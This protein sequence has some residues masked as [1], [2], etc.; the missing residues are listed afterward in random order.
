MYCFLWLPV[1]AGFPLLKGAP[2]QERSQPTGPVA[3]LLSSDI[4]EY[5][6]ALQDILDTL[7]SRS[8]SV[9][10]RVFR[11]NGK[12]YKAPEAGKI[13]EEARG[14]HPTLYVAI[15]VEA[16][17][18]LLQN[19]IQEPILFS[20][21]P[22]SMAKT[23]KGQQNRNLWHNV[24]GVSLGD[25]GC[26]LEALRGLPSLFSE[27]K[28]LRVGIL[29]SKHNERLMDELREAAAGLKLDLHPELLDSAE[30]AGRAI[31]NL[32][33]EIKVDVM[34]IP[35]DPIASLPEVRRRA[36][37]VATGERNIPVVTIHESDLPK[38]ALAVVDTDLAALSKQAADSCIRWLNSDAK[39]PF[40]IEAPSPEKFIRRFNKRIGQQLGIKP[41][42]RGG[43]EIAE[44][45]P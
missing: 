19:K 33:E 36:L 12:N 16:T 35:K 43:W 7:D 27:G 20:H 8:P 40:A 45:N 5:R 38:G 11:L 41:P 32:A 3:I 21:L 14:H 30:A 25:H 42:E 34:L 22:D 37:E 17:F 29:Y 9:N 10:P 6:K 18:L 2:L 13:L 28:A 44:P 1:I 4:P 23:I 39:E 24:G 26:A 15:G 31:R